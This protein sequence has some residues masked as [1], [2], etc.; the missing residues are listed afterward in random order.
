VNAAPTSSGLA[1]A[2]FL[3]AWWCMPPIG[4]SMARPRAWV[5]ELSGQCTIGRL[6]VPLGTQSA[7]VR[8]CP[9]LVPD[10]RLSAATCGHVLHTRPRTAA[11]P[12]PLP[13]TPLSGP[14]AARVGTVCTLAAIHTGI[15]LTAPAVAIVCVLLEAALTVTIVLTA[16]YAPE[17][18]S[19]RAFRMLPWTTP[20]Q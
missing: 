13:R 2:I 8:P 1:S 16:L 7:S 5:S 12:E 10:P 19:D 4:A 17:R 6:P 3:T 14:A 11:G 20:S 18:I 9:N 15:W